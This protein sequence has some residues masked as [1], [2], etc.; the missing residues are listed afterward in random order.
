MEKKNKSIKCSVE[1]CQHNDECYCD[2]DEIQ[3]VCECDPCDCC[4]KCETVCDSFK[5]KK[6]S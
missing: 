6:D 1:N 4:D 3:V 2:L 5:E